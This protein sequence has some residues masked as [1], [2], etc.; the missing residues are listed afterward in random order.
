MTEQ[1]LPLLYPLSLL[2]P[3]PNFFFT[4]TSPLP[5][6]SCFKC[7]NVF[8]GNPKATYTAYE[9]EP[10]PLPLPTPHAAPVYPSYSP[11]STHNAT[12]VHVRQ[13]E[14][15]PH[16]LLYPHTTPPLRGPDSRPSATYAVHRV[17]KREQGVTTR[18]PS[19]PPAPPPS[20]PPT[21]PP[22]P[23]Q[24]RPAFQVREVEMSPHSSPPPPPPLPPTPPPVVSHGLATKKYVI[25]ST[26]SSCTAC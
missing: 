16:T 17:S 11:F 18:A 7:I 3:L 9:I 1:V 2:Y 13:V 15:S 5:L 14:P 12:A 20:L 8:T 6:L 23:P 26:P 21:P 24:P 4:L 22:L 25:N 10:S 19:S